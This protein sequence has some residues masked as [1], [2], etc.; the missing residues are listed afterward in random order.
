MRPTMLIVDDHAG[1]RE[2]ARALLD[3]EGFRV[4]G[5]AVDGLEALAEVKRLR[6]EVVLLDVQLPGQDGFV[7][8]EWIAELPHP[9]VVVLISGR[10][11]AS[12]GPRLAGARAAGFIPKPELSGAALTAILG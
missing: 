2:A 4:V 7:V 8:A 6:P 3:A 12:Y 9:P 5:E 1:F 11:G 10:P